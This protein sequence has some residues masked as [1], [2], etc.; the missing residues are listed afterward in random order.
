[1]LWHL[2]LGYCNNSFRIRFRSW[3]RIFVLKIKLFKTFKDVPAP[4]LKNA[5]S[6]PRMARR[7]RWR[8]YLVAVAAAPACALQPP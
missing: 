3:L 7:V 6:Q 5:N 2:H 8:R 1:M 4:Y